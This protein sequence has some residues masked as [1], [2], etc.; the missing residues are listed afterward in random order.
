MTAT[1]NKARVLLVDDSLPIRELLSE[2]LTTR[3]CVVT[4][5]TDGQEAADLLEQRV[6]DILITDVRIP[7][8]DGMEILKLGRR[9]DPPIPCI[10]M[11]G[12]ATVDSAVAAFNAGAYDYVEKPF[13]LKRIWDSMTRALDDLHSVRA[14]S[15]LERI[16]AMHRA[17]DSLESGSGLKPLVDEALCCLCLELQ[18]DGAWLLLEQEGHERWDHN[19]SFCSSPSVTLNHQQVQAIQLS[20]SQS[21]IANPLGDLEPSAPTSL[22]QWHP[23][24][25]PDGRCMGGLIVQRPSQTASPDPLAFK[26]LGHYALMLG[27]AI[28]RVQSP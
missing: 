22:L 11:T 13:K 10:L 28:A 1:H 17:L 4:E 9:R 27:H 24:R 21:S 26:T 6:F 12:F 20:L 25:D 15:L 19:A 3:G 5:A 16:I 7:R 14:R 2:Y 8:I 18:T 23:I